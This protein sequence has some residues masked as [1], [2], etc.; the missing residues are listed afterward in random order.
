MQV[1]KGTHAF[2][3]A[4]EIPILNMFISIKF[5][6]DQISIRSIKRKGHKTHSDAE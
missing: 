4:E 3:Q 1:T 2:S 6:E 5:Y